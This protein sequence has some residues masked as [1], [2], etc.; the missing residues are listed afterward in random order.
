MVDL[1]YP[2]PAFHFA[3]VIGF[4]MKETFSEVE[5]IGLQME[6]TLAPQGGENGVNR[7]LPKQV[8]SAPLVLKR[9]IASRASP[10]TR[11]CI[12]VLD[13]GMSSRIKTNPVNVSLLDEKGLPV[14]QWM[15]TDAYP[16]AWNVEQFSATKN[17][18]AMETIELAYL[19][20]Q[21]M[22]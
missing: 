19:D 2:A 17:D 1:T 21:R 18:V 22:L 15:F 10:M 6:T 3:V 14:V 8:T 7:D 13:Q 9:K 20:Q 12:E 5:G 11:W 4:G 16:T